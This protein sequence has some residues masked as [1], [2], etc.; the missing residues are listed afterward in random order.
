MLGGER[1]RR[2][3]VLESWY[4]AEKVIWVLTEIRNRWKGKGQFISSLLNPSCFSTARFSGLTDKTH[5]LHV[6]WQCG[7]ICIQGA[8]HTWTGQNVRSRFWLLIFTYLKRNK[9]IAV[10][11][12]VMRQ[13]SDFRCDSQKI[14]RLCLCNTLRSFFNRISMGIALGA[15][16]EL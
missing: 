12:G 11:Q 9:L 6:S 3:Q 14:A 15:E 13:S 16:G 4:V 1:V 5:W 7:I 2:R 10:L 8:Q